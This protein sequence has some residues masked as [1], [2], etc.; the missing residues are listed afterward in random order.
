MQQLKEQIEDVVSSE[1][2]IMGMDLVDFELVKGKGQFIIRLYVDK[3]ND[4]SKRCSLTI[5]D[6]EKVSRAIERLL[7]VEDFVPGSYVLEVSTP[8]I[9][10]SLRKIQ[11]FSRFIGELVAGTAQDGY[12]Q[13]RIKDVRQDNIVFDINGMDRTLKLSDI[14]KAKLKF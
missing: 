7:E 9:E 6:C 4:T 1:L 10:R 2:N 3:S 14:K 12:F 11:D 8:G 5:A 13:G